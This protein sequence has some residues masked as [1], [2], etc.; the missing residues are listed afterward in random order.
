M[1]EEKRLLQRLVA[2]L[3]RDVLNLKASVEVFGRDAA[4]GARISV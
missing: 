4:V 2:E 1:N 3:N